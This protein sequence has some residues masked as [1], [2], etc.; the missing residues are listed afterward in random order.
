[1]TVGDPGEKAP[2][3]PEAGRIGAPGKP[4]LRACHG[5]IITKTY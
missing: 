5:E 4:T 2:T 3:L 1:V